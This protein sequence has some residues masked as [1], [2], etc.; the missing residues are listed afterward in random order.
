M[1]PSL[2]GLRV[3]A[4]SGV[5]SCPFCRDNDFL[6]EAAAYT[7]TCSSWP[8][9]RASGEEETS[10]LPL[11]KCS[12]IP[13]PNP[14]WSLA[15]PAVPAVPAVLP[16]PALGSVARSCAPSSQASPPVPPP[17]QLQ[18]PGT[19]VS[20]WSTSDVCRTRAEHEQTRGQGCRD[21]LLGR[22]ALPSTLGECPGNSEVP[23]GSGRARSR[24][25]YSTQE[26][27]RQTELPAETSESDSQTLLLRNLTASKTCIRGLQK[28]LF[29]R[30]CTLHQFEERLHCNWEECEGTFTGALGNGRWNTS[31]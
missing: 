16:E 13:I 5:L 23:A 17:A 1:G 4:V 8:R 10:F 28:R 31:K 29:L 14:A 3:Q 12:C 18:S 19:S 26:I 22:A 30:R 25:C 2:E 15:V 20:N 21:R 11:V 24:V 27:W 7:C 9:G 6:P